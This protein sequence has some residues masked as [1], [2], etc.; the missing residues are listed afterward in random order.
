MKNILNKLLAIIMICAIMPITAVRA[1]DFKTIIIQGNDTCISVKNGDKEYSMSPSS[2]VSQSG[3]VTYTSYEDCDAVVYVEPAIYTGGKYKVEWYNELFDTPYA[4]DIIV[5][6]YTERESGNPAAEQ[7]FSQLKG[8]G[9]EGWAELGVFDIEAGKNAYLT[10]KSRIIPQYRDTRNKFIYYNCIKLT[11]LEENNKEFNVELPDASENVRE[12]IVKKLPQKEVNLP[13]PSKS[14]LKLYVKPGASG[15]G[16]ISNPFGTIEA[17]QEKVKQLNESGAYPSG[18]VTVYLRDGDYYLPEGI[19]LTQ[20]GT[21]ASPLFYSSYE[22]ETARIS[23]SQ[24]Y[25]KSQ[26]KKIDKVSSAYEKIP[27]AVRNSVYEIP[28]SDLGIENKPQA[29]Y[30]VPIINIMT[31]G[32]VNARYPND[33]T[34]KTG[35]R[36]NDAGAA[37]VNVLAVKGATFTYIPHSLTWDNSELIANARYRGVLS[38]E[39]VTNDLRLSYVDKNNITLST[40]NVYKENVS[41]AGDPNSAHY[42]YNLLEELDS[43]GEY[44]IDY[45]TYKLYF[46][47]KKD[48]ES[49]NI[50]K[51]GNNVITVDASN[52]ILNNLDVGYAV[53]CMVTSETTVKNLRIIG[54][55]YHDTVSSTLNILDLYGKNIVVRDL[56]LYNAEN[57]GGAYLRSFH[58]EKL[59]KDIWHEVFDGN[60][61]NNGLIENCTVHDTKTG[62]GIGWSN[63][64]TIK[65]NYFY[66]IKQTAF[67][68]IGFN[69]TVE[70]NMFE[71]VCY[72]S[73]D[74]G[75]MYAYAFALGYG[76]VYRYNIIKNA[77]GRERGLANGIYLDDRTS[78]FDV[79]GN[80]LINV[81]SAPFTRNGGDEDKFHNNIVYSSQSGKGFGAYYGGGYKRTGSYLEEKITQI[82]RVVD[83][84]GEEL[85]KKIVPALWDRYEK[86]KSGEEPLSLY[87]CTFE[88][89]II[90]NCS[91]GDMTCSTKYTEEEAKKFGLTLKNLAYLTPEQTNWNPDTLEDLDFDYIRQFVPDFEDIP[92]NDIGIYTG[93][94]RTQTE[95]KVITCNT[96]QATVYSPSNGDENMSNSIQ[97]KWSNVIAEGT[98]GYEVYIAENKELTKNLMQFKTNEAELDLENLNYGKTYYWAVVTLGKIGNENKLNHGGVHSFSTM[99]LDMAM[100][101]ELAK[102]KAYLLNIEEGDANGMYPSGTKKEFA[103]TVSDLEK[104]LKSVKTDKEK[105]EF[106]GLIRSKN[107]SLLSKKYNDKQLSL[108]YYDDFETDEIGERAST[109]L[110]NMVVGG[111][112]DSFG[113]TM[114]TADLLDNNNNVLRVVDNNDK[115]ENFAIKDI[116]GT[117]CAQMSVD[118]M[119]KTGNGWCGFMRSFPKWM[120]NITEMEVIA[121][122]HFYEGKIYAGFN[123]EIELMDYEPNKWYNVKIYA[124]INT[125]SYDVY[126]DSVLL[127][128]GVPMSDGVKN[129]LV[130]E[131]GRA[132]A[133]CN[134]DIN[135]VQGTRNAPGEWYIDNFTI[136]TAKNKGVSNYLEYIKINGEELSEFDLE[137]YGYNLDMT[138]EELKNSIVEA[139][140]YGDYT[141]TYVLDGEYA[142]YIVVFSGNGEAREYRLV[143]RK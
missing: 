20:G 17:A 79:Y 118:I 37:A 137:Q 29:E 136:F 103:K 18:G 100:D 129:G 63:N 69:N 123:K 10:V 77:L 9:T 46:I 50:C 40:A 12:D 51:S 11:L 31:D 27:K 104:K 101:T 39:Y 19:T 3:Y 125:A 73:D 42:I 107:D 81:A 86:L 26:W 71:N 28:F 13:D 112:P 94:A 16:S 143:P 6:V 91:A 54:G 56:D 78:G 45:Q 80:I 43:E 21:E 58:D 44:V 76:N 5:D 70:Y 59:G 114:I 64:N 55:K 97:L 35:A 89:S 85:T 124:N 52:I 74:V 65:N 105:E 117:K 62:I 2:N 30:G 120:E 111:S 88:D 122:V 53:G 121:P 119:P 33:G 95:R 142:K 14:E 87:G 41:S 109:T 57:T 134:S 22:N 84:N 7:I 93:G 127:A 130:T 67:Q 34:V 139:K 110:T 75:A 135:N 23:T 1:T 47:P 24:K 90:F 115:Q 131:I 108:Y 83:Y 60:G 8:A 4:S 106:I 25:N 133:I 116:F 140:A 38:A 99:S 82:N 92:V 72:D 102:S 61:E 32:Y 113:D 141:K 48:G 36:V 49:I 132:M 15:D 68:T 138:K 96:P 66:N 128:D 98:S 126:I